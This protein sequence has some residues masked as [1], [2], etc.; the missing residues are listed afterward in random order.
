MRILPRYLLYLFFTVVLAAFPA[1]L[2][3]NCT[4][5]IMPIYQC[6]YVSWFAPPPFGSGSLSTVWWQLGYGN[7]N[8]IACTAAPGGGEGT[9]ISCPGVFNGNDSGVGTVSMTSADAVLPQYASQIPNGSF[10]SNYENSWAGAGV[11]GCAD[12][13]RTTSVADND[14]MLNPYWS[15]NYGPCPYDG[16]A[17]ETTNYLVDYPMAMLARE[18][19]NRFFAL[20]F[21][22]SRTRHGDSTDISEGVF[23]LS[24]V[25]NGDLNQVTGK[26]N[27]IPWQQVPKIRV[28]SFTQLADPNLA[29]MGFSWDPVRLVH[30]GSSRP[31]SRTIAALPSGG[32]GVLEQI[33]APGGLCRY[34]LQRAPYQGSVP[35]DP[36][37]L[38]WSN[39]GATIPCTT[40]SD[41]VTT[42]VT[43][44]RCSAVRVRTLLGK[45]PRTAS[46]LLSSTRVGASGDL[47]FEATA[48]RADNCV[49]SPPLRVLCFQT[50]SEQA[51]DTVAAR[52]RNAVTVS[53]RTT[54]ELTVTDIDILGK[55]S[56]VVAT[57]PCK[58]CTT[59]IGDHY[60]VLLTP[61][62]LK[63]SRELRVRLNG[64]D[65][66]SDPF[67]IE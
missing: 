11:D 34:Q 5:S 40:S 1:R 8:T 50:V 54:S 57:V 9:G 7:N 26:L 64:P 48:C 15:Q 30:D 12:N 24:E 51:V 21:I 35:P 37:T 60:E 20:A 41:P 16:C 10:C 23:D 56:A 58:Q 66:V 29:T 18:S 43:I 39:V 27:V 31:N 22:A 49:E 44:P 36:T 46:T 4:A 45:T 55:G 62:Q 32:V 63:W 42:T 2:H 25:T 28:D 61:G 6:G 65:V 47:G 17:Y 53:F 67:P 13:E 33:A 38:T 19:T 3:A 14:N 59:G 52:N